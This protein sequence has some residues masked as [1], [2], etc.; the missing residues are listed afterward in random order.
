MN[1]YTLIAGILSLMATFGHF[2]MGAKSYMKPVLKSDADEISKKVMHSLF[3]YMSVFMLITTIF[4]IGFGIGYNMGFENVYDVTK[5]IGT[6][7]LGFA[8]IQFIIALTSSI[9]KAVFKMFQWI[10]WVL[11]ATFALLGVYA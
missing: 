5:L 2:T 6:I 8:I 1:Y 3:H 4:L 10:F 11:I 7:Y 9:E